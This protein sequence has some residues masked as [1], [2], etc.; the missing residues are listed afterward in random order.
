M[1]SLIDYLKN[2]FHDLYLDYRMCKL[3]KQWEIE[4]LQ[5]DILRL[6]IEK[7]LLKWNS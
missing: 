2:K 1:R 5:K 6:R 4:E 7:E 3:E